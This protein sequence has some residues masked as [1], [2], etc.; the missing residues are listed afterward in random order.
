[1]SQRS[2]NALLSTSAIALAV[3]A[4]Q[5][6]AARTSAWQTPDISP[7][8][9]YLFLRPSPT[10]SRE[11][12]VDMPPGN[13]IGPTWPPPIV[14]ISK[15]GSLSVS[16][17][18]RFR[19]EAGLLNFQSDAAQSVDLGGLVRLVETSKQMPGSTLHRFVFVC[20]HADPRS[21]YGRFWAVL[22]QLRDAGYERVCIR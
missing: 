3:L 11:V 20:I 22:R 4:P 16:F 5:G 18:R 15:D 14:S 12:D 2:R 6:L 1:L 10:R 17:V 7:V 8:T 13:V 21:P 19:Y 9:M